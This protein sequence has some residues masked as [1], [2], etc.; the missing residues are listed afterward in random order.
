[1][2]KSN[3]PCSLAAAWN[4]GGTRVLDSRNV[5][6]AT[7][8]C[9]EYGAVNPPGAEV[10]RAYLDDEGQAVTFSVRN[11]SEFEFEAELVAARERSGRSIGERGGSH[12]GEP[13]VS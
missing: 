2:P 8:H 4:T 3:S 5:A 1:M 9:A 12:V 7:S 6:T 10:W 11:C 13:L